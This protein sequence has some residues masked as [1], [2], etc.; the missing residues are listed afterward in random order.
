MK[1]A[2]RSEAK[3]ES[4]ADSSS[5][6]QEKYLQA[7]IS[8][9]PSYGES[10]GRNTLSGFTSTHMSTS[11]SSDKL[12][13]PKIGALMKQVMGSKEDVP[14]TFSRGEGRTRS[15]GSE[16]GRTWVGSEEGRTWGVGS[17][18]GRTRVLD[19]KRAEPGALVL[20]RAEPGVSVLKRAE[21][22]SRF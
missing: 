5:L 3:L 1:N 10:T 17:E 7:I 4:K 22:G 14:G 15:V 2:Q 12:R 16:E 18:E 9:M 13:Q 11:D 20:K 21:P 8:S 19:L 6:E